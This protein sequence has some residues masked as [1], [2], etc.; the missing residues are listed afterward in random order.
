M[1]TTIRA[2]A[3]SLLAIITVG[4]AAGTANAAPV[5]DAATLSTDILP[6]VHYTSNTTDRSVVI[7]TG[8]GTFT[9]V[10]GQFQVKDA[11]DNI[12]AGAAFAAEPKAQQAIEAQATGVPAVSQATGLPAVSQATGVP[13]AEPN[14]AVAP[15]AAKP[16]VTKAAADSPNQRFDAAVQAAV[17]EFTLATMAGTMIGGVVGA[18]IGCGVGAVAGAV[19]GAPILDGGG[20]TLIAGCLAGAATLGAIGAITGSAV[21]GIPAGIA[22]AVKYDNT[23]NAPEN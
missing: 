20:L 16:V 22:S 4:V 9:T 17:N 21:V 3:I 13:A 11:R 18:G 7:Q 19:F 10:G 23:M 14:H 8:F 2:M 1:K 6:G 12:V 5:A 15:P